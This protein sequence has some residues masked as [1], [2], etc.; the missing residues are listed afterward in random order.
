MPLVFW[1]VPIWMWIILRDVD[2]EPIG[3]DD[4]NCLIER[5]GMGLFKGRFE[6]LDFPG[7]DVSMLIISLLLVLKLRL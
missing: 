3:L 4:W 7:L 6:L 1:L 2:L 5:G